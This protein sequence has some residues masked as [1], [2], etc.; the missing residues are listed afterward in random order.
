MAVRDLYVQD[1][2]RARARIAKG[3]DQCVPNPRNVEKLKKLV[4]VLSDLRIRPNKEWSDCKF[5]QL[6][7]NLINP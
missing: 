7:L 2:S 1:C 6:R 3:Y 4:E 5:E